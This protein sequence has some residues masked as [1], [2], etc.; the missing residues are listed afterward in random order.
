MNPVVI[1]ITI[2]LTVMMPIN[3]P[4]GSMYI[5][6][7]TPAT[8]VMM[9]SPVLDGYIIPS[10]PDGSHPG[11][12]AEATLFPC[13]YEYG[14]LLSDGQRVAVEIM[15][16]WEE[17]MDLYNL[18]LAANHRGDDVWYVPFVINRPTPMRIPDELLEMIE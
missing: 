3:I 12:T 16:I 11:N 15:P 13:I 9:M 8:C 14:Y 7:H 1:V 10:L 17:F 5:S 6:P 2:T 4:A 18:T